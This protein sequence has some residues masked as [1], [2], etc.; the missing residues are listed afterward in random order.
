MAPLTLLNQKDQPFTWTDKCEESFQELNRRLTSAPILVIPDVGKPFE[1]YCDAS[2]LGLGCVLMQEK[3]AVAYASRQLKVHEHNYPTHDLELAA[4]V[5]AL[6]IWR[7]YLYG[8]QFRAFSDHKS[9]KYLFDQNEL[10]MR[11][12]RW[13]DFLKDY[14]F[15]LLYYSGK[16]NVVA[17]AL[18][19]KTMHIAHLMIK[20]VELLEKFR[21]MKLQVELGSEFIRCSTLTISSDFL[22][23]IRERQ[24]LDASLN[25]V[26]EQ[27]R[28]DEARDFALGD[29]GIL[30]FQGRIF[31]P[32]DAEVKKLILEE[33]HKSRLSLHPGMTKMYQDLKET[34][35]WQGMKKDVAQFVSACLTCQKAKVEHQRPGE[36][37]QPLEMLVWKWDSISMDFVTHL[38][39]TFRGHDTIWVIVDRLTKSAH[40]LAMNLRMA[41]AR[42]AQLYMKEITRLHGVSSSIVSDRDSRFT[43]R[44]LQTLQS[45]MGSK[46]TMSSAYHPQTDGQFERTI[47][48]LEDLLRTCILDYLGAWDEVLPLIEFTYN[49]S[50]HVS[51]GMASYETLYG[52]RCRTPLCWYQDGEAVLVGLELL[53]QTTKKVRIVRNRMQASQSRQKAYADRKRRPLE[54]AAGDHVFLRVTQT[55]SVGRALRSRKLSPKFLGPYQI[56]RRIGPMAYEIALPPQLANLHP[57]FHVSQL[58]KYVFDPAHVFEAEDIQIRE[59]LTMEV[60]PIALGDSKVEENRG[61][62]VNLFKVIWD[63]RTGDSTWELEEDMRKSHPHLFA[64]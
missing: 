59:D 25:R 24:L 15:E 41:M 16:A 9:L 34:F 39:Q 51:I 62:T 47:Q 45:A 18:T 44:F 31:V 23:S 6:K 50:F 42:L 22:S 33:G 20:E 64:C 29:D 5:F 54:F 56:S 48:S 63:R 58:R 26:R 37:L 21:D 32:N 46:L 61:K 35:W 53:E 52:R 27:L 57:V 49:N 43:S 30:R 12:R 10:N 60:P 7:H 28:S 14:N 55:T 40:F 8:A 3:K 13:M 38:P 4:I 2:H 19:R 36:N 17:N 11:Q 1:V